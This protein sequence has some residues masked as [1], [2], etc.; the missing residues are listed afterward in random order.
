MW[1]KVFIAHRPI[2]GIGEVIYKLY[3]TTKYTFYHDYDYSAVLS[4]KVFALWSLFLNNLSLSLHAFPMSITLP[5]TLSHFYYLIHPLRLSSGTVSH[6]STFSKP[7]GCTSMPHPIPNVYVSFYLPYLKIKISVKVS[8]TL[9]APSHFT[10]SFS[11]FNFQNLAECV[12][13]LGTL[14]YLLSWTELTFCSHL[15]LLAISLLSCHTAF[16][17]S[18]L[19]FPASNSTSSLYMT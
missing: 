10:T 7:L 5:E 2:T 3:I 6:K 8:D 11:L 17:H 12:H 15:F 9:I 19:F 13:V 1:I 16:Q 18:H 14:K 4:T